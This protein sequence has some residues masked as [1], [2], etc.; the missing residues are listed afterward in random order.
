MDEVTIE[1]KT[2][3]EHQKDRFEQSAK[4]SD[5]ATQDFSNKK[6]LKEEHFLKLYWFKTEQE[7]CYAAFKMLQQQQKEYGVG[8]IGDYFPG[9]VDAMVQLEEKSISLMP[10][11]VTP[12]VPKIEIPS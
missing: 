2:M 3:A 12:P 11:I 1:G 7:K 8:I 4:V 9:A 5:S 10:K 6:L